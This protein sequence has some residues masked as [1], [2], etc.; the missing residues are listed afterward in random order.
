MTLNVVNVPMQPR[1]YIIDGEHFSSLDEFY[2]EISRVL[3]PGVPWGRNLD[4]FNDILRGGFGT[5]E[6]G[7]VLIWR[8]AA[9]S[10]HALG[11]PATVTFLEEVWQ[12]QTQGL[13]YHELEQ[14]DRARLTQVLNPQ[15]SAQEV[16]EMIQRYQEG[17]HD[18][19]DELRQARQQQGDTIFDW[20][21]AIIED[22]EGIELRLE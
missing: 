17:Y 7:F 11:Y 3:I 8:N 1:I 14:R 2:T 18:L 4:A 12:R 6:E 9:R 15:Q 16:D 10:Q 20:L 19:A 22:H 13:S 5:P 21:I